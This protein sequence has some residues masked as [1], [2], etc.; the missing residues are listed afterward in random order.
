[1]LNK[2]RH[3]LIMGEILRNIYN[4]ISLSPLLGF[5]GG[6]CAFFFYNLPRFSVDLDFDLF[7]SEK[8]IK[9]KIFEKIQEIL[10]KYGTVKNPYIKKN[11]I[12]AVLSY[13]N[14]DRNIK[15]EISTREQISNLKENYEL[16]KY[17]GIGMLVAEKDYLFG[18]KLAA[19]TARKRLAMRD[20]Y[21]AYFF[22]KNH[23]DINEEVVKAQTGKNLKQQLKECI[24]KI[25]TIQEDKILESLGELLEEK[26][27]IWVKKNLKSEAL[28]ML[29][30]YLAA[31]E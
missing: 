29:R 10:K 26:E 16:K 27:K 3:K 17:L 5:K 1:M 12:F 7:S 30:N 28:F 11:T 20:V 22:A 13:G 2:Q 4:D 31:M 24:K 25:K 6:T 18:S 15:V 23:W 21:D 9:G 19:L 8:N 14:E